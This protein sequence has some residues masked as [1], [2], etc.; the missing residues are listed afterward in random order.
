LFLIIWFTRSF[1]IIW[2]S[3]LG[4]NN[5]YCGKTCDYI[6]EYTITGYPLCTYLQTVQKRFEVTPLYLCSRRE[7]TP[8]AVISFGEW[9]WKSCS[10]A[11]QFRTPFDRLFSLLSHVH[12]RHFS[13]I[14]N[15]KAVKCLH[16]FEIQNTANV[17]G[18]DEIAI[19]DY[20]FGKNM[21][22]CKYA[23]FPL[24]KQVV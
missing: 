19:Y 3:R 7:K 12:L 14:L 17:V 6:S 1:L 16:T 10:A 22:K 5:D 8:E 2:V 20:M 9:N 15:P 21:S 18:I 11:L 23:Y 24:Y 13:F 4:K